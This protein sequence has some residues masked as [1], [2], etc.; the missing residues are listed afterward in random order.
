MSEIY[1]KCPNCKGNKLVLVESS[2]RR[3]GDLQLQN[4]SNLICRVA[5]KALSDTLGSEVLGFRCGDC[6]HPDGPLA[7]GGGKFRWKTLRTV[8]NAK[9]IFDTATPTITEHRCLICYPSGKMTPIIVTTTKPTALTRKQR[10]SILA[11]CAP[12]RTR[13]VLIAESDKAILAFS[14]NQWAKAPHLALAK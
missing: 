10:E 9:A 3:F 2:I 8:H 11:Q 6:R 14:P 4:D 1:F 5:H 7:E 13:A 12:A